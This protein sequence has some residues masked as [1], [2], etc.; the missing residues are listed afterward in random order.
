M[1]TG[2]T[3]F[4]IVSMQKMDT[5][6]DNSLHDL[7]LLRVL[8]ALLKTQSITRTGE[9][10]GLSQPAASRNVAKL[11]KI[12]S[13]PLL[14]RTSKGYVLTPLAASLH[15]EVASALSHC[16]LV[17]ANAHFEPLTSERIFK[18]GT[19]D[20]GALTVISPFVSKFMKLAPTSQ[21]V[22]DSWSDQTLLKLESG[23][24]DL[25]LY[26]D[27]ELP[28]DFHYSQ[29]FEETYSIIART[30]HPFLAKKYKSLD[31]LLQKLEEE[32][33]FTAIFPSG[34]VLKKDDIFE[35]L[36]GRGITKSPLAMP[37]FTLGPIV[38]AGSD[39]IMIV[40]TRLAQIFSNHYRIEMLALPPK[41]ESFP[42]RLIWH[43]RAQKDLGN[44]WLRSSIRDSK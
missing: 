12:L 6:T 44:K 28:P 3:C 4:S 32:R 26:A 34:R 39:L 29:L 23:E 16:E 20:Y 1:H 17:F 42:Y 25:A 8:N 19:T 43:E 33:Q 5:A 14:I 27:E 15:K 31:I 10:L 7:N 2:N 41:V 11:R 22:I 21:I 38:V 36:G 37:Y 13:D 40:P 9:L 24:L 35:R 18:I 30:G